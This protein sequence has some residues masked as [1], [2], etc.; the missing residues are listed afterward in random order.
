VPLG[1]DTFTGPSDWCPQPG[2]WHAT[3]SDSTEVEVTELV[4]AFVRALQPDIAVETGAAW[5][6]TALAIGEALAANG[7]GELWTVEPDPE[8]A[9]HCRRK[10]S[11]L[12]H[13][14]VVEAESLT[15]TPP[16]AIGFAWFDSL[17][18]LR[19]PEFQQYWTRMQAGTIVGFHDTAPHKRHLC[20]ELAKLEASGAVKLIRLRTPRGVSFAEVQ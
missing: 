3:D 4:A 6:Q 8:R 15:W 2:R 1:E 12:P 14:H 5:G 10:L 19:V 17:P 20:R 9:A 13:V 16:D 18:H 7:H 11:H